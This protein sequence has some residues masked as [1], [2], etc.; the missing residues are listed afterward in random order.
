MEH[1]T[2][3]VDVSKAHLDA[4]LAPEGRAAQFP[5]TAE[6]IRRLIEWI[7][8][9]PVRCVAYEPTGRWHRPLEAALL[10]AG[11]PAAAAN[12]LRA[13]RFA[14]AIGQQAKTDPVDAAML[15][16]MAAALPLRPAE[17]A[18]PALADLR[19]LVLAREQLVKDRTAAQNRLSQAT[20][21]PLR[22]EFRRRLKQVR[23]QIKA[24]D[25]AIAKA[26]AADPALARKA[27]V[28]CSVP[29]I[30]QATAACLVAEVP[31]LGSLSH[32]AIACL[33]GLAPFANPSGAR[34]G[35]RHIRAGRARPRS[36]LHMP[37]LVAVRHNPGLK[38][39]FDRLRAAGKPHK[40]ALTAVMRSLLELANALLAQDR[41]WAEKAPRQAA[42]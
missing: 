25:A 20:L 3:G 42:A 37:A 14:E 41:P 16:A 30:S 11:L 40:V 36:A 24:V 7:G 21:A 27:E 6:G 17:A 38:A 22:T 12:P 18:D 39:K 19:E 23:R 33:V 5:N 26:L 10:R 34:D 13:R 32:K 2:V 1:S 31:E 8:D 35:K 9:A 28:L 4:H 15:A 29:G